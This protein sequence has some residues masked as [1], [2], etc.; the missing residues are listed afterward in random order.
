MSD[1]WKE[2]I[3]KAAVMHDQGSI[4]DRLVEIGRTDAEIAE[5]YVEEDTVEMLAALARVRGVHLK[6]RDTVR[7]E[8]VKR[9]RAVIQR[10]IEKANS[11]REVVRQRAE[12]NARLPYERCRGDFSV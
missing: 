7:D 5:T 4:F 1:D 12:H 10:L 11:I 2:N 8:D 9:C 3:V 6:G